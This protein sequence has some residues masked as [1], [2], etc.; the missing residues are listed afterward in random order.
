MG[1]FNGRR[2]LR[3]DQTVTTGD[4]VIPLV[5]WTYQNEHVDVTALAFQSYYW[6]TFA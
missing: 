1:M 2:V 4:I 5:D 3:K 6:L